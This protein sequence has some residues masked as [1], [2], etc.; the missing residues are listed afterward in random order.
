VESTSPTISNGWRNLGSPP[1]SFN[2]GE[3]EIVE[4]EKTGWNKDQTALQKLLLDSELGGLVIAVPTSRLKKPLQAR[5]MDDFV[6]PPLL[7]TA[8]ATDEAVVDD[9]THLDEDP[10]HL[11]DA[12]RAEDRGMRVGETEQVTTDDRTTTDDRR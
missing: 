6:D 8:A 3:K 5:T 7:A 2:P 11:D 4:D 1:F 9:T 12:E 10:T